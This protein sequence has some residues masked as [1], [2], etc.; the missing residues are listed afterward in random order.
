MECKLKDLLKDKYNISRVFPFPIN[1][2]LD[3]FV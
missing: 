1:F 3:H 2:L